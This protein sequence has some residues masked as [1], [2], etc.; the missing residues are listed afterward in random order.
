MT[1]E[2]RAANVVYATFNRTDGSAAGCVKM[3]D[4]IAAFREAENDG[5]ADAEAE[6]RRV[7][8]VVMAAECRRPAGPPRWARGYARQALNYLGEKMKR[9]KVDN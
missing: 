9:L 5:V 6:L 3:S 8:S 7:W 4:L 2:Q 1:P